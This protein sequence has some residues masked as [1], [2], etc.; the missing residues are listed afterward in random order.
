[1]A[2]GA[3]HDFQGIFTFG[4]A[5]FMLLGLGRLIEVGLRL[6]GRDDPAGAG[7]EGQESPS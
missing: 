3:I 2:T 5:F 4:L 6:A 1:M 7:P